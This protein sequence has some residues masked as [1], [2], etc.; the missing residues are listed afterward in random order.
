MGFP[1]FIALILLHYVR[2]RR[3]ERERRICAAVLAM[4]AEN[5]VKELF[6]LA[7]KVRVTNAQAVGRE[8]YNIYR[9]R[10]LRA[11]RYSGKVSRRMIDDPQGHLVS[12]YR[13][14]TRI[15]MFRLGRK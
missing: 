2:A 9:K 5:G 12:Y 15:L 3:H 11:P 4:M 1:I 13:E 8:S 10:V 14:L 7:A 6:V